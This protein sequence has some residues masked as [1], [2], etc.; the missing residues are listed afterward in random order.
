[1]NGDWLTTARQSLPRLWDLRRRLEPT[2][3][4]P[5][6]R[7]ITPEFLSA[8]GLRGVIWD[9]DGTLMEYHATDIASDFRY[10]VRSLFTHP[11]ISHAILSNCGDER[12]LALGEI[13]PEVPV[14]RSYSLSGKRFDR[15]FRDGRDSFAP[16]ELESL[17]AKGAKQV[18]KPDGDLIRLAIR[19]MGLDSPEEVVMVGDQYLTDIASANL[20]G[21]RSIKVPAWGRETFPLPVRLSQDFEACLFRFR[22]R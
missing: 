15:V 13:F 1:M 10:Q 20:A 4:L 22:P 9:V 7:A 5:D 14:I 11:E 16:N 6:I 8:R 21:A 17:Y 18:R 3:R 19:E 12:F 2:E